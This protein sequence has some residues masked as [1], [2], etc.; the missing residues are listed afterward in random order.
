MQLKELMDE[1][2]FEVDTLRKKEIEDKMRDINNK[3]TSKKVENL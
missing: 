3:L 1:H 2:S